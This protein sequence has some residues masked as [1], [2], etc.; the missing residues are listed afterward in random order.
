MQ[1][2]QAIPHLTM[3]ITLCNIKECCNN[4]HQGMPRTGKQF[5]KMCCACNTSPKLALQT[6]VTTSHVTCFML[7][8]P[9]ERCCVFRLYPSVCACV[10]NVCERCI[11]YRVW[12]NFTKFTSLVYSGTKV[13]LLDFEI[14]R[15]KV[16]IMT[17]ANWVKNDEGIRIDRLSSLLDICCSLMRE[18]AGALLL[19]HC[20]SVSCL[21]DFVQ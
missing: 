1:R 6:S 18:P 5:A 15:L 9:L 8:P 12:G 21:S 17:R 2:K 11:L 3:K 14:R 10:P 20:L 16:K 4:T 19:S 7:L 13:N